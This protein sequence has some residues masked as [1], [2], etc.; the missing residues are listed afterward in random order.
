MVVLL[1]RLAPVMVLALL[2]TGWAISGEGSGQNPHESRAGLGSEMVL[3]PGGDFT[4]GSDTDGDHSPAHG[5][6]LQPF[7][8]GKYEVTNAE[9]FQFC[10]ATGHRLPEFWGVDARR[11]GPAYPNH[12]VMGI[13]WQDAAD[14][15]EWS[16]MRLPTEAE[17]EYVAR[18]GVAGLSYPTADTL[19]PADA[20]YAASLGGPVE[21]GSYPPNGFGVFDMSGNVFEWV[22]DWYD[23]DYYVHSS[24]EDPS[25][26][27]AGK[28]RVIRGGSWHSGPFCLRTYYRNGLPPQWVDF[29]VGIRLAKDAESHAAESDITR[30]Q[31]RGVS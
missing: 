14:Y 23:G 7:Y 1:R 13:S 27:E 5:V 4:M 11:S 17:W 21:V 9:Y 15:A 29:G 31:D 2:V 25:G 22:A 24:T 12:P 6:T 19:S 28:H 3:V 16:G 26:P 30:P 8:I 10:Q 20:N 18:G